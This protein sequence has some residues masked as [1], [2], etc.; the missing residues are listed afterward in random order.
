M[1]P[2]D[3]YPRLSSSTPIRV[4]L[5]SFVA[6]LIGA[7]LGATQGGQTAQLRFRA[8]HAHKMPD[9]TAGW[10]LYHKSK[11]YHT[12]QGGVREAFRMGFRT[13]FWSFIALSLESTVDNC[14]GAKDMFSTIIASLTVAGAFSVWR[15]SCLGGDEMIA[16]FG[17]PIS[18][19]PLL[20]TCTPLS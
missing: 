8:E 15:K 5:G 2:H 11:N 1:F 7:S 6:G 18:C 3:E 10:Y 9:S 4:A 19:L 17:S 14:R 16:S 20:D 12:M 13:S